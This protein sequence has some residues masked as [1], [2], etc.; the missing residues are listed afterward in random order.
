MKTKNFILIMTILAV[1]ALWFLFHKSPIPMPHQQES[2]TNMASPPIQVS[3]GSSV[4]SV[5]SNV[6][7]NAGLSD[8]NSLTDIAAKYQQGLIG[9]DQVMLL[10]TLEE[11]KKS[12][13]FY[14]KVIDQFGQPIGSVAVRGELILNDG[15][16]GGFNTKKFV[17]TT[18][19]DGLFE[20]TDLHGASFN[21]LINKDGYKMGDRGEGFSKPASGK[22]SPTDRAILTM[23]KIRGSEPLVNSG[24]DAKITP[25]GS[26]AS[27][28]IA[29]GNESVNG[30]FRVTLLR[31]PLEAQRGKF[32][33]AAKVEM[34]NG[35]LIEENDPY[36]YLAP[37]NGYQPS[38]EFNVSSND[39]PW[40]PYLDG[41]FYIKNSQGQYG[42]MK[43]HI[44]SSVTP[45]RLK[46][47]FTINPSGSQNLEPDFSK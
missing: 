20:F 15:T 47:S 2:A 12:Q 36:P 45:A 40:H 43:L 31:F 41:N 37:A 16:Y 8:T 42:L 24:I 18:D 11:N 6:V 14:G 33:W 32:D 22:T 27:F 46:A 29:T 38:F 34:L 5:K 23:W 9:K 17:A 3:A 7:T 30:N 10:L 25:D 39:V 19:G 28:D 44:N 26:P 4:T 1:G 35:G 21:V 13:D